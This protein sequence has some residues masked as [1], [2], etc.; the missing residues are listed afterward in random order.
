MGFYAFSYFGGILN[1]GQFIGIMHGRKGAAICF[2]SLLSP[3]HHKKSD[4]LKFGVFIIILIARPPVSYGVKCW[5]LWDSQRADDIKVVGVQ[6]K[7]LRG[8]Y[9]R[10]LLFQFLNFKGIVYILCYCHMRL[11][12]IMADFHH[13][14]DLSKIG[15]KIGQKMGQKIG[16]KMGQKMGQKAARRPVQLRK[17]AI[18][19][20]SNSNFL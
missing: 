9:R 2:L 6:P 16:Q 11:L 3:P 14:E 7:W 15:Q 13:P 5:I 18:I 12:P 8:L 17:R 19:Q 10:V 20:F 4:P 1:S